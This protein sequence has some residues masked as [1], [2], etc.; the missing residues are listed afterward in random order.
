MN[1]D[2][3]LEFLVKILNYRSRFT[4]Q[5]FTENVKN[6]VQIHQLEHRFISTISG[7]KWFVMIS[8]AQNPIVSNRFYQ[9]EPVVQFVMKLKL[10]LT[11]V[12]DVS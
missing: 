2:R 5:I 12:L 4:W 11:L 7:V 3:F 10:L 9:K 8:F 1:V 6:S